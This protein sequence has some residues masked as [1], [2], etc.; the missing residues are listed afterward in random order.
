MFVG[1]GTATSNT[2]SSIFGQQQQPAAAATGGLFG[3]INK[4]TGGLFGAPAATTATSGAFSFGNN[5]TGG[6]LFGQNKASC[7]SP[8]HVLTCFIMSHSCIFLSLY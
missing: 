2:S 6:G 7:A 8:H 5:T 3:T 1:F 4:P